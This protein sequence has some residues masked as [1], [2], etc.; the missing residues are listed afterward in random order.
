MWKIQ[1]SEFLYLVAKISFKIIF[2][3]DFISLKQTIRNSAVKLVFFV[4]IEHCLLPTDLA[5]QLSTKPLL[6]RPSKTTRTQLKE[7]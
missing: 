3:P 7:S 2:V 6:P 4:E 1:I 5:V